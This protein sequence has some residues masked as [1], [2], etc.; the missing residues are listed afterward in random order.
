[1]IHIKLFRNRV[2]STPLIKVLKSH[3][4]VVHV[5]ADIIVH[6]Y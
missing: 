5:V 6:F 1:M 3:I 4:V 2:V